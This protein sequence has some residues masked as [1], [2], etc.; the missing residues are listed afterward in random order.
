MGSSS[1]YPRV[2]SQRDVQS[3]VT[4][5]LV[6]HLLWASTTYHF[7]P[8]FG[9]LNNT[10]CCCKLQ[11]AAWVQPFLPP[12]FCLK[13]SL[14]RRAHC[15]QECASLEQ[16]AFELSMRSRAIVLA[17]GP[18]FTLFRGFP[19][20]HRAHMASSPPPFSREGCGLSNLCSTILDKQ[21]GL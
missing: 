14:L 11:I 9:R 6:E 4:R 1:C 7:V 21:N 5:E 19:D 16:V 3:H 18:A 20:W 8:G 2:L 10:T 17:L 15:S 12:G 13:H